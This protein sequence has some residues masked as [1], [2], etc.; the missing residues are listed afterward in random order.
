V[1]YRSMFVVRLRYWFP[2]V[3]A[4]SLSVYVDSLPRYFRH[5]ANIF[6]NVAQIFTD[7]P[8]F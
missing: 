4:P 2:H 3:P 5:F 7:F 1:A 8:H 6:I